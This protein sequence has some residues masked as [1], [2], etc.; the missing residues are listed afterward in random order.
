[1]QAERDDFEA[2]RAERAAR[3]ERRSGTRRSGGSGSRGPSAGGAGRASMS[4]YAPSARPMSTSTLGRSASASPSARGAGRPARDAGALGGARDNYG[5]GR[6]GG[7][8]SAVGGA[9]SLAWRAVRALARGL[10]ALLALLWRV[11]CALVRVLVPACRNHPRAALSA[12]AVVAATVFV[13]NMHAGIVQERQAAYASATLAGAQQEAQ[14]LVG[15]VAERAELLVEPAS[16]PQDQWKKG[17][18]PYLYQI[19]PQWSYETYSGGR[20][21]HQGCGPTALSM[22]YVYLTGKTDYDPAKMAEFSTSQGYSTDQNGTSWSLMTSGAATLGLEG[23]QIGTSESL[24]EAELKAGRPMIFI[25]NPGHFTSSGHF[26]VVE[27]LGADGKAVVHDSNSWAR[28]HKT[29][30]LALICSEA[31]SSWSFTV[32]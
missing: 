18:M 8:A 9:L 15:P 10:A 12:A 6:S 28:S 1:M 5:R 32:S 30:D 26:I 31:A 13:L 16:T 17:E 25:M 11:L 29:W 3:R 7:S 23:T 20:L 21:R 2:R 4:R 19:D 14:A 27:K 22:V 24:A